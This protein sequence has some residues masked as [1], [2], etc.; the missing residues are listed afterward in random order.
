MYFYTTNKVRREIC[1]ASQ[2][3][4]IINRKLRCKLVYFCNS[5]QVFCNELGNIPHLVPLTL[6]VRLNALE[7]FYFRFPK[8]FLTQLSSF[9]IEV[10]I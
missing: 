9:Q 10:L 7:I 1:I 8:F 2:I 4:K 5:L 6:T 3:Y